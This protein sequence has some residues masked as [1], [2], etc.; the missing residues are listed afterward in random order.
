[1]DDWV[2]RRISNFDYLMKLNTIAGRSYNDITQYPVFPWVLADYESET[3][4]LSNPAVFRDLSKPVGALNPE[5]LEDIL[6]D[7]IRLKTMKSIF[8]LWFPL[9]LCWRRLALPVA[10]GTIYDNGD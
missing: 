5:R 2:N 7:L 9:L 4:N 8:P 1:M 10:N 6:I 3:I